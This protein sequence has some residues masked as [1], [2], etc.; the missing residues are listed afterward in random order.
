MTFTFTKEQEAFR[1]EVREFVEAELK[2]GTFV[3]SS[4]ALVG[5]ISQEFS[6]KMAQRGWLGLT[7]PKKYGGQE[8]TYVEK[9]IMMEE[10]K[11]AV[12]LNT[13]NNSAMLMLRY[14][15]NAKNRMYRIARAATSTRVTKPNM[16]PQRTNTGARI[17]RK[18]SLKT[19]ANRFRLTLWF[20]L[21]Y[22]RRP[23]I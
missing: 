1:Q 15:T 2:A 20:D 19:P 17:A 9:M 6:R 3:V 8:R 16:T 11:T 21:G 13:S 22:S 5:G 18:V 7:W 10:E 12:C 4:K 23:L 14:T